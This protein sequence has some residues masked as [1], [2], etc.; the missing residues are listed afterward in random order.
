MVTDTESGF[1]VKVGDATVFVARYTTYI[2]NERNPPLM[3]LEKGWVVLNANP[4]YTPPAVKSG[5][6]VQRTRVPYGP[7]A[8]GMGTW[9]L[10]PPPWSVS[11]T[12]FSVTEGACPAPPGTP[13]GVAPSRDLAMEIALMMESMGDSNDRIVIQSVVGA[14]ASVTPQPRGML[15]VT[16]TD[17]Q[18][19]E[20]IAEAEIT[21]L[22][23]RYVGPSHAFSLVRGRAYTVSAS[24]PAYQPA[25]TQVTLNGVQEALNLPLSKEDEKSARPEPPEEPPVPAR[26]GE[27]I[28]VLDRVEDDPDTLTARKLLEGQFASVTRTGVVMDHSQVPD[29]W[30]KPTFT[31]TVSGTPPQVLR[32]GDTFQM[33]IQAT[34][35]RRGGKTEPQFQMVNF[36]AGCNI[37]VAGPLEVTVSPHGGGFTI[38]GGDPPAT[39]VGNF[40]IEGFA[41][42]Q[43]VANDTRTYTITVQPGSSTQP[44]VVGCYIG[45]FG[46]FARYTYRQLKDGESPPRVPSTPLPAGGDPGIRR[47]ATPGAATGGPAATPRPAETAAASLVSAGDTAAAAGQ[48][49]SAVTAYRAAVS[50]A[51]TDHRAHAALAKALLQAGQPAPA[52][53]EAFKAVNL[54]PTNE[55]YLAT[56]AEAVLACGDREQ[57][58]MW[59]RKARDL[60]LDKHPVFD[61]LGLR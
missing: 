60:G 45:G 43:W 47:D 18:T 28:W 21:V 15:A 6:C 1:Y 50:V 26:P 10:V 17:K 52:R 39:C 16:V 59:A 27:I 37:G 51:P 30:A 36:N 14:L 29:P 3:P 35:V 13:P 2:N 57:A 9:V 48:W 24:A 53:E 8:M 41:E 5:F 40:G 61:R 11:T 7:V 54:D 33:A 49:A 19:G 42:R 58:L 23:A 34:G 12:E 55:T 31:F 32:A 56:M 46:T 20:A 44:P 4:V 22:G 38:A 25:E